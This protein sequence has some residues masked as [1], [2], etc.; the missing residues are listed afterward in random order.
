[1]FDAGDGPLDRLEVEDLLHVPLDDLGLVGRDQR[2]VDPVGADP[3]HVPR[4]RLGVDR[5]RLGTG[6]LHVGVE[7]DGVLRGQ[8]DPAA[9]RRQTHGAGDRQGGDT[10]AVRR[11]HRCGDTTGRYILTVVDP[12]A[13]W[14][15]SREVPVIAAQSNRI[16]IDIEAAHPAR[17]PLR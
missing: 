11:D 3:A 6:E 13:Q 16:D 15:R 8:G 9:R 7:L 4:P 2:V 5:P 17:S 1:V 10:R 14:A 12:Y